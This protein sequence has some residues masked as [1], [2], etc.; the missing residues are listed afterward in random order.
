M[1]SIRGEGAAATAYG[2]TSA[3][4]IAWNLMRV[5][6]SSVTGSLSATMPLPAHTRA[7][8]P[9]ISAQRTDTAQAPLPAAS[10]QPAAPA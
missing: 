3:D 7:V 8:A 1:P 4:S 6:A 10:T 2:R 9:S 5:S